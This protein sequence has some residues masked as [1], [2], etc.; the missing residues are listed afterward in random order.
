MSVASL[1][2]TP[3]DA[4]DYATEF[5][6]SMPFSR[7]AAQ[8]AQ[9][10]SN[11]IWGA[12][13]WWWTIST[14]API[15][16]TDAVQ[17]NNVVSPPSDFHRFETCY[18]SEGKTKRSVKALAQV[19]DGA[20]L[21]GL[22]NFVAYMDVDNTPTTTPAQIWFE[23][24]FATGGRTW[25][26][27]AWYKRTAPLLA[28]AMTTPGALGMPDDYYY[29]YREGVL[30]YAFKYATDPRAGGAQVTTQ[31]GNRTVAYTGQLGV[32]RAAIEELR[33]QETVVQAFMDEDG[34]PLKDS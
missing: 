29:V 2:L 22:P 21:T 17:K 25:K 32:Y 7:V 15:T 33:Q 16:L 11:E 12:A 14:L 10:V 28:S 26:F 5:V 34:M 23:K 1:T 20:T 13:P 24:L 4:I 8:V 19:P 18:I 6:K 30:Y 31:G 27:W 9:D 3:Q